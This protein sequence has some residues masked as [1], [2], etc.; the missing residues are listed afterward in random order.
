[1]DYKIKI[2]S[3][4]VEKQSMTIDLSGE[5]IDES[6]NP[7]FLSTPK[8]ILYFDNGEED[9]RIPLV[10]RFRDI[11]Y[12]DGKCMF[13]GIYTY[14][15]DYIFWKTRGQ[16]L[17]F[18]M[19]FNLNFADF[20]AERVP[21]DVTP[22][23]FIQDKR[24]FT[25][26][27]CGDHFDITSRP[28]RIN[29]YNRKGSIVK[30]FDSFIKFITLLLSLGLIPIFI[31]EGLLTFT[32]FKS[33]PSKI[34]SENKLAR[35]VSYIIYR[36]A[37]VSRESLTMDGYKRS[38]I[39]RKYKHKKHKKVQ[40]NKITFFSARREEISGNFEFVYNKIKD[41]KNLDINFL[42]NTKSFR[43]MTRKEIDDFAEACA[44]SKVIILDEFTPQ[45][46]LIDIKP[47]TKIVQLWHA[48]GAFKTFGFTRLGKPKGSPQ[49]TRMHRNYDY[50]TVSSDY[51]KK[52]HS[53][54]FGIAT[55]NVVPTG[56]ARTDIFFDEEYKENFRNQ[57]YS[58]YPNL[59]DKKIVLFAPTFRG[60]IKQTA[61]YPMELFDINEVCETLGDEYAV[62]IKHHPFITE[63][64]PIPEK[65]K[66]RVIDLSESTEINDLLFISD[67]IISD[68]SS[69]VF[70]ASLLNIPMLFYA[71][72]LQAYIKS[73]DFY[74]D[75]K[76]YIPGKICS[77]LYELLQAIKEEDFEMEKIERFRNMFFDDLDGKSSE[78]IA[79]LI[80]KCLE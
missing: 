19:Y 55:K 59:K 41:D 37:R 77:S 69:L 1:M 58:E 20:Y 27:A 44:T 78:R 7:K 63:Q 3:I 76:L 53:E 43:Y 9:R 62:I 16:G 18:N 71:Y 56:I 60:D 34:E 6:I 4:V 73:R 25:L 54:G 11:T 40:P 28:D 38:L 29:R 36:I 75:F 35:L 32:G 12:I 17:P 57:F 68:Y 49:P 13:S 24:F 52:C 79:Q 8:V 30:A 10:I 5:F 61:R 51:C 64:H 45:I 46:H 23:E 42:F 33:M 72:D 22:D 67:V 65:Y 2:N 66:D 15:L 14:R 47:E 70:E 39:R 26:K 50:V 31:I 21:I 80:Y 48:C 74:F